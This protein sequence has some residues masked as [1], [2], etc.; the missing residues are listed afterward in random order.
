MGQAH[1]IA[2]HGSPHKVSEFFQRHPDALDER[3]ENG[4]TPLL[5][6]LEARREEVAATLL[7]LGASPD[8]ADRHGGTPLM[9]A[10]RLGLVSSAR[11]LVSLGADV[12]GKDTID[13]LTALEW[14]SMENHHEIVD[15]LRKRIT[16]QAGV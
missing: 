14:A 12:H 9:A 8:K 4:G 5:L 7:E 10:A 16:E 2:E 3:D 11:L 13:A 15:L 6:A 1:R